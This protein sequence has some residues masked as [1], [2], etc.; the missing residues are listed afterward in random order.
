MGDRPAAANW[1][2]KM[3]AI[4]QSLVGRGSSDMRS[5][6]ELSE[7][8]ASLASVIRESN[9]ARAQR[10]YR[11]SFPLNKAIVES[12][13]DDA[14]APRWQAFNRMG[15]AWVLNQQL[16]RTEAIQ[17]LEKALALQESS[18]AREP[19]DPQ[20]QEELGVILCALGAEGRLIRGER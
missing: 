6:F 3:L 11:R 9:P 5:Q 7:A 12:K 1:F 4:F 14:L 2:Q 8:L 18:L 15:L 20:F 13:P 16:R 19:T 17:E 10:L